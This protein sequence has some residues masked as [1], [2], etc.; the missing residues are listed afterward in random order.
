MCHMAELFP[1]HQE[2][3]KAALLAFD[4]GNGPTPERQAFCM[5]HTPPATGAI[6]AVVDVSGAKVGA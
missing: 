6:E 5:L 4:A 3:P 2:P 1:S